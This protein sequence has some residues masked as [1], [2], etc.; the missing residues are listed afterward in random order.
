MVMY[1][2]NCIICVRL[3]SLESFSRNERKITHTHTQTRPHLVTKTYSQT[4]A[5]VVNKTNRHIVQVHAWNDTNEYMSKSFDSGDEN[6]TLTYSSD[7]R[8][9]NI[10]CWSEMIRRERER[11]NE[12]VRAEESNIWGE[13][14]TK[15]KKN[16]THAKRKARQ[17][18]QMAISWAALIF[19]SVW[20]LF[21]FK[22]LHALANQ[23]TCS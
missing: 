3:P 2:L 20:Q 8:N 10:E 4:H 11:N 14:M 5:T 16:N 12:R 6:V 17:N 1:N 23:W 13:I 15:K 21:L 19:V 22:Y 7:E 18:I 9:H